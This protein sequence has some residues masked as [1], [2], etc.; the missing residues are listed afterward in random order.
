MKLVFRLTDRWAPTKLSSDG[1]RSARNLEQYTEAK[2]EAHKSYT[3]WTSVEDE[4]E[5]VTVKPKR[6][7]S[8]APSS[9][10]HSL[11]FDK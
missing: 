6:V 3:S 4:P 7:S 1:M 2:D 9:H 5:S 8:S 11:D 10:A